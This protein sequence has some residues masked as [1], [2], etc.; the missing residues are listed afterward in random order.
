[1]AAFEE[2]R[3]LGLRVAAIRVASGVTDGISLGLDDATAQAAFREIVYHRFAH[4][5]ASQG[6]CIDW[7]FGAAEAPDS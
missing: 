7:E 5:V 2:Q 4:K 3:I 6:N 1:V